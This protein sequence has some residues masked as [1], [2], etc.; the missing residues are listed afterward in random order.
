MINPVS[1]RVM[2]GISPMPEADA[3][4][5]RSEVNAEL[6]PGRSVDGPAKLATPAEDS[7]KLSPTAQARALRQA[8]QSIPQIAMKLGLAIPTVAAFFEE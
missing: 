5:T 2:P 7:V 1:A 4:K 3:V 8:G 6:V